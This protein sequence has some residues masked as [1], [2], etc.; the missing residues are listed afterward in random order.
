MYKLILYMH[1]KCLTNFQ[2]Q[3]I[4]TVEMLDL[5]VNNLIL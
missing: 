5:L 2:L 4:K 3:N 1:L